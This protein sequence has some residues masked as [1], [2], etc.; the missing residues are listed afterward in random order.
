MTKRSRKSKADELWIDLEKAD[1]SLLDAY[2]RATVSKGADSVG[3]LMAVTYLSQFEDLTGKFAKNPV[4]TPDFHVGFIP[5]SSSLLALLND[6]ASRGMV[7]LYSPA[8]SELSVRFS[9]PEDLEGAIEHLVQ[10]GAQLG[11]LYRAN[12]ENLRRHDSRQL[13]QHVRECYSRDR[14]FQSIFDYLDSDNQPD[15]E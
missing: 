5:Y 10:H 8:E 9:S 4:Y 6:V 13:F 11:R 14:H 7:S 2:I 3:K 12:E 15:E 1:G